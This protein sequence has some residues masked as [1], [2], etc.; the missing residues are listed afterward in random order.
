LRV[1]S[2]RVKGDPERLLELIL[3]EELRLLRFPVAIFVAHDFDLIGATFADENV[4]VRRS[5]EDARITKSDGV[6]LDLKS[7]GDLELR[8]ARA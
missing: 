1:G 6:L 2:G 4:A 7:G 5:S 8:T 3:S